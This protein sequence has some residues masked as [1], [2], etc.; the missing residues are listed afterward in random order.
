MPDGWVDGVDGGVGGAGLPV[1]GGE[2][3]GLDGP[4]DGV[5]QAVSA[6]AAM[7]RDTHL[8]TIDFMYFPAPGMRA[9]VFASG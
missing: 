9:S 6:M 3:A 7:L 1:G 8:Q 5:A 4:D 2:G